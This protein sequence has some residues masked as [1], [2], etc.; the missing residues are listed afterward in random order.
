MLTKTGYP[1]MN[2][3]KLFW[4]GWNNT[5]HV[6]MW[7]K[8]EIKAD[9]KFIKKLNKLELLQDLEPTQIL[10]LLNCHFAYWPD[11]PVICKINF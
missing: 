7:K 4:N 6:G 3:E 2:I 9:I 10:S 8:C 11:L 1:Q 5:N